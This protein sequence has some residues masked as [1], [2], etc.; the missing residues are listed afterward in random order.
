MISGLSVFL[1]GRVSNPRIIARLQHHSSIRATLQTIRKPHDFEV[2]A[3]AIMEGLWSFGEATRGS[4]DQ[5][6]DAIGLQELASIDIAL[7]AGDVSS[8]ISFPGQHVF[9][10]ASSKVTTIRR[11]GAA[12]IIQPPHIRELIGG[13]ALQRSEQSAWRRFNVKLLSPLQMVLVTTYRLS[14]ASKALCRDIGIQV[15]GLPQLIYLICASAPVGVFDGAEN[16][17]SI[18]FG[19]WWRKKRATRMRP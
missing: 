19:K 1:S 8:H 2:L 17:I 9:V 18:E 11:R 16:F 7:N 3:A 14:V 6:M 13:W 10:F 4:G 5:G 12:T 15:W